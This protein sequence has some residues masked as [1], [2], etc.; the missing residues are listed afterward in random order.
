MTLDLL[1][2]ILSINFAIVQLFPPV[3]PTTAQ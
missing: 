3:V 2:V 1:L